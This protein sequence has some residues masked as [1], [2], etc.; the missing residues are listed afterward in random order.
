MLR[1]LQQ[2]PTSPL[3]KRD[4]KW[5]RVGMAWGRDDI[6]RP[7]GALFFFSLRDGRRIGS[8]ARAHR[9]SQLE[10]REDGGFWGNLFGKWVRI[11]VVYILHLRHGVRNGDVLRR[12]FPIWMDVVWELGGRSR[13]ELL[14]SLGSSCHS[15]VRV[16]IRA[17]MRVCGSM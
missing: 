14:R 1:S 11:L 5:Q 15:L 6:G 7:R 3:E 17:R 9:S 4:G 8:R 12:L 16:L 2:R 10:G 13:E